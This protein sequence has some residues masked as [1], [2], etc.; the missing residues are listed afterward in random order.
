MQIKCEG[1]GSPIPK[2]EWH[3]SDCPFTLL[4]NQ[5]SKNSLNI[6]Y[7]AVF[8]DDGKEIKCSATQV[9]IDGKTIYKSVAILKLNVERLSES[10]KSE[11]SL[12]LKLAIIL[13]TV[14]SMFSFIGIIFVAM[15][16]FKHERKRRDRDQ[17][18]ANKSEKKVN[19]MLLL[20]KIK[21]SQ[22]RI[23]PCAPPNDSSE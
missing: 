9:N 5:N 16:M 6:N 1:N 7:T 8:E 4:K 21:I 22:T 19:G 13:G 17:N 12:T 3:S 20:P 18:G 15:Y 10:S 23:K 2:I 14:V 11:E